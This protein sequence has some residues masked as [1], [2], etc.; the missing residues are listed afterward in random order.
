LPW[1]GNVRQ[2]KSLCTWLTIMAP[3]KTVHMEDLPLELKSPT[4]STFINE[5]SNQWEVMLKNWSTDFLQSGREGLHT[6]AESMFEK[7]FD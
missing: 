2:L 1:P 7:V 6:C 3:D 5:D 4:E